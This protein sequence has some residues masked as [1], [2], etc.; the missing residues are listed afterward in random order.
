[1]LFKNLSVLQ[2]TF[3]KVLE[4]QMTQH[5]NPGIDKNVHKEM[6]DAISNGNCILITDY[7]LLA[8][9][10]TVNGKHPPRSL[11]DFLEKIVEWCTDRGLIDQHIK[12]DFQTLIN[13]ERLIAAAYKIEEY[14][15]EK[16]QKEQCLQDVILNNLAKISNIHRLITRIPFRGYLSTTYDTLLE[17]A[18]FEEHG[19]LLAKFYTHLSHDA[20]YAYKNGQPFVLKL[21]GDLDRPDSIILSNRGFNR[22]SANDFR[23]YLQRFISES[24]VLYFGFEQTCPDLQGISYLLSLREVLDESNKQWIVIPEDQ[25]SALKSEQFWQSKGI[26]VITYKPNNAQ[27]ELVTFLEELVSYSSRLLTPNEKKIY[28]RNKAFSKSCLYEGNTLNSEFVKFQDTKE[29]R[30][31]RLILAISEPAQDV[32]ILSYAYNNTQLLRVNSLSKMATLRNKRITLRPQPSAEPDGN[33]YANSIEIFLSSADEDE[34]LRKRL[35]TTLVVLKRHLQQEYQMH[36]ISSWSSANIVAGTDWKK[37]I[38]SHLATADVILLL[39]ST[40][41]LATDFCYKV[42]MTEAMR[43]HDA[44]T[45]CVIPIV[46][47]PCSWKRETFGRLKPLPTGGR[48]VTKWRNYNEAFFNVEEG[49]WQAIE[50]LLAL[51]K[52]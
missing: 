9:A 10:H 2:R 1:V 14:L 13:G 33:K 51:K 26:S 12:R 15:A 18:Y 16:A 24:A 4:F 30:E 29:S 17:R 34:E 40:Y 52:G 39:V 3:I 19:Q 36:L 43:K 37:E 25:L 5:P 38:E 23:H 47:S 45:A 44:G 20:F 11:Q 49:I 21:R 32:D 41:F 6:G 8:Q 35:E 27:T 42:E 46:L 31:R 22:F 7:G 48:P 28:D 50:S